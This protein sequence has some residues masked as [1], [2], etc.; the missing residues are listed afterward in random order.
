MYPCF[1]GYTRFV[2]LLFP[3]IRPRKVIHETIRMQQSCA[4]DHKGAGERQKVTELS[5]SLSVITNVAS[6]FTVT[7]GITLHTC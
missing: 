7:V 5:M 3:L 4:A 2:S 6:L 1:Q